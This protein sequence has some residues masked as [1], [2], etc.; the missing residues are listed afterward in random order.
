MVVSGSR[1]MSLLSRRHVLRNISNL[2]MLPP[3]VSGAG[4]SV[5]SMEGSIR[6]AAAVGC[7][8]NPIQEGNEH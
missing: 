2:Q 5:E 8:S 6:R 4:Y 3:L 7:E 1:D